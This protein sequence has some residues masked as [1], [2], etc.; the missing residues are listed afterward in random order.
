MCG[1]VG[2]LGN[3]EAY[4]ILING[5]K[6]LE[7]RGY[8]SS[9]IAL[10]NGDIE[11]YKCKGKVER[12]ESLKN[13][14]SFPARMGIGTSRWATHGPP[15]DQHSHTHVTNTGDI[16]LVHNELSENEESQRICLIEDKE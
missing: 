8:D 6:R 14:E 16:G 15:N 4:P 10:F 2:Y 7:Y 12:L 1:I 11:I 5:L 3:K 13:K 9:G